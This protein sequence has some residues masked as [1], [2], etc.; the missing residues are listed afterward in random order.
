MFT[1]VLFTS[2]LPEILILILGMLLL[3]VEPFWKEERRRNAGWLTAG[4]LL[5]SMLISLL[6]APGRGLVAEM[7]RARR[8]RR[9]LRELGL[10]EDLFTLARQ[11]SDPRHP[12]LAVVLRTMTSRPETVD[13]GLRQLERRGLV[14]RSAGTDTWALTPEGWQEAR[15]EFGLW[16]G[17]QK[18]SA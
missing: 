14:E 4:G 8:S 6:F 2:I 12:H 9:D 1:S 18:E 11:H 7:I 3:I 15:D 16:N 17:L 13:P 10:L 5:L